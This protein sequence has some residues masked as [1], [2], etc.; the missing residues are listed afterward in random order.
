MADQR[1]KG[2]FD[3]EGANG[4]THSNNLPSC[5]MIHVSDHT[6]VLLYSL[7][8]PTPLRSLAGTLALSTP[9]PAILTA[10]PTL[11]LTLSRCYAGIGAV[12]LA[13]L[14]GLARGAL[15]RTREEK[16]G[17]ALRAPLVGL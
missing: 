15:L 4:P 3:E 6:N 2:A 7:V 14:V 9:T 1:G 8:K 11:T 10:I 12:A 13:L 5:F 16:G 17:D